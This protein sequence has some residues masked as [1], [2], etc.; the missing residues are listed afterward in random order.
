MFTF[1]VLKIVFFF[2]Q[3]NYK[4]FLKFVSI[5][6]NCWS[7]LEIGSYF[8]NNISK[9]VTNHVHQDLTF[10]NNGS[11]EVSPI[12]RDLF[13]LVTLILNHESS[14]SVIFLSIVL[15]CLRNIYFTL[16]CIIF[17]TETLNNIEFFIFRNILM[18]RFFT[19][20][21]F[22]FLKK[23][24]YD[25]TWKIVLILSV[26]KITTSRFGLCFLHGWLTTMGLEKCI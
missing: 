11:T 14:I 19:H 13:H 20:V 8:L 12:F 23:L 9:M 5:K 18:W 22:Y 7:W 10:L 15:L 21:V 1:W 16:W 17:L 26:S 4:I 24:A 2:F 25:I 3:I 6:Y